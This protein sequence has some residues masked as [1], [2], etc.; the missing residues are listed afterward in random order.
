MKLI[1]HVI[2][3]DLRAER[4]GLALWAALYLAQVA[5]GVWLVAFRERT[6]GREP[7]QFPEMVGPQLYVAALVALQLLLTY[8]LTIRFIR[9]DAWLGNAFWRTRPIS[10]WMMYGAKLIGSAAVLG[11][12][13]VLLLLPWWLWA[14]VSAVD[15]GWLAVETVGFQL[16]VI[17]VGFLIGALA[18]DWGRIVLWSILFGVMTMTWLGT[19]ITVTPIPVMGLGQ[20][21]AA[22]LFTSRVWQ[23]T[24]VTVPCLLAIGAYMAVSR[25]LVRSLLLVVAWVGLIFLI[26]QFSPWQV[27]PQPRAEPEQAVPSL[28]RE[29]IRLSLNGGKL[30]P[31]PA[32]PAG[33]EDEP[34]LQVYFTAEDV[35][36]GHAV[37]VFSTL[38]EWRW[39][40]GSTI[41]RWGQAVSFHGRSEEEIRRVIGG[42][43][44]VIPPLDAETKRWHAER[45]R[46][47]DARL[48]ERGMPPRAAHP[49]PSRPAVQPGE[50][51]SEVLNVYTRLPRSIQAR[52]LKEPAL[53]TGQIGLS[54]APVE[55]QR[56][57]PLDRASQWRGPA[58]SVRLRPLVA[59]SNEVRFL[60]ARLVPAYRSS[61]LWLA[62]TTARSQEYMRS[63]SSTELYVWN[64]VQ[65]DLMSVGRIST[66]KNT[67]YSAGIRITMD[68]IVV[69]GRQVI[70]DGQW[71]E[72]DPQWTKHSS[73]FIASYA[74]SE[75]WFVT[76]GPVPFR[77]Q[78]PSPAQAPV[79]P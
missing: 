60:F 21:T 41:R 43:A 57:L 26:G 33:A 55:L 14:G 44:L 42:A 78:E 12:G 4:W 67:L 64:Y 35:P 6:N 79:T 74:E 22:D 11:G 62:G 70:R 68:G 20:A 69:R 73:L 47:I 51:T 49:S 34:M 24:V 48:R 52:L 71:T 39:P 46:Q 76:V 10:A 23:A 17:A 40:G 25:R 19:V 31:L 16:L 38:H 28:A 54:V 3:K 18:S 65:G 66:V 2:R 53:Y 27:F 58:G 8:F 37:Q 5:L 50:R 32:R 56:D 45:Q 30:L 61:G 36:S 29:R 7:N 77:L 15:L 1:W 13:P 63:L 59:A 72:V 75:P 9:S